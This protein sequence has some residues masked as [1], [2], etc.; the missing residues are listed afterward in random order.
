MCGLGKIQKNAV[1]ANHIKERET[2]Y[3]GIL[4][5]AGLAKLQSNGVLVMCLQPKESVRASNMYMREKNLI[6]QFFSWIF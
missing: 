1:F 5:C 2:E 4:L 3:N 6:D